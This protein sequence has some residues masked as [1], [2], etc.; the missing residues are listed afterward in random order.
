M[1]TFDRREEAFESGF[2]HG[3]ELRFKAE[4]RRDKLIGLWAA[5]KLGLSGD[6][7]ADYARAL[8]AR[9]VADH[10]DLTVFSMIRADFDAA[11]VHQSDHQIHRTM[12]ELFAV[13]IRELKGAG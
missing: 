1:T 3:E 13:A 5:E 7:A 12:D 9:A 4:A 11:G 6:A 2:M 10:G 8:V